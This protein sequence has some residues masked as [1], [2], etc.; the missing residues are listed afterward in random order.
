M[1]LQRES[2]DFSLEV[3]PVAPVVSESS[4]GWSKQFD[5]SVRRTG[6]DSLER[7]PK[8]N[9]KFINKPNNKSN[10]GPNNKS[11]II[12][13]KVGPKPGSRRG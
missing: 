5:R 9:N 12:K 4:S 8:S 3:P 6:K 10:G 2:F 7:T 11:P 1:H 13:V